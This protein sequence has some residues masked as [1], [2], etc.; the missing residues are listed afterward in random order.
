[1]ARWR[2]AAPAADA[3]FE[4]FGSRQPDNDVFTS[5]IQIAD[6]QLE[7]D[8]VRFAFTVDEDAHELDVAVFHPDFPV[9]PESARLQL[10]FLALD[11]A[12]GEELVELCGNLRTT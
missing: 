9:L 3:V 4:Y 10:T 2:A 1:V 5:R 6:H 12:L 11:W 7:L 8:A